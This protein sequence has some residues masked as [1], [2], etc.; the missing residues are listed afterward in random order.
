MSEQ[1][2]ISEMRTT[3]TEPCE[4]CSGTGKRTVVSHGWLKSVRRKAGLSLRQMGERIGV[5]APYLC[6]VEHGHRPIR[7]EGKVAQAYLKLSEEK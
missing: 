2:D 3:T 1:A 5:S 7:L 4:Y 6:D